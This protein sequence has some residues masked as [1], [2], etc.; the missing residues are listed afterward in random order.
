VHEARGKWGLGGR[1]SSPNFGLLNFVRGAFQVRQG[2]H[3]QSARTSAN[4]LTPTLKT[5]FSG[6]FH[7]FNFD[8]Y[9]RRYLGGYC[10]RFNRR[11]SMAGMTERIPNSVC[12]CVSRIE[13]DL[14]IAE[15][16][17]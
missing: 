2:R 7:A 10:F 4:D 8:K 14:R 9:A 16:Y 15:V 3:D 1:I 13:R 17:G 12:C 6:T 5:S 11:F